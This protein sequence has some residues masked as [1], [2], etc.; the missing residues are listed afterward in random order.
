MQKSYENFLHENFSK[1]KIH[2]KSSK[3]CKSRKYFT[4]NF[5]NEN[6]A[7][8]SIFLLPIKHAYDN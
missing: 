5:L 7:N 2:K 8:Y 1:I 3:F 4:S 6:K